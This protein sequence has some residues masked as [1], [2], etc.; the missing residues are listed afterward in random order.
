MSF[1]F[2]ECVAVVGPNGAGK[3]SLLRVLAGLQ[4]PQKGRVHWGDNALSDISLNDRPRYLSIMFSNYQR[5][6]GM[7]VNDIVAMG[8]QPYTGIFGKMATSDREA[9]ESALARV[10]MLDFASKPIENLS[11]G[12]FRKVMLAKMWAQDAQVMLFDE[13]TA[14]L[15]FPSALE[16]V[17]LLKSAAAGDGKAVVYSSHNLPLAFKFAD[18]VLVLCENGE[19][20]FDRPEEIVQSETF[21]SI[22]GSSDISIDPKDLSFKYN[23]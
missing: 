1:S 18:K 6:S 19:T 4:E 7:T 11:D 3:S 23:A 9:V 20:A 10:G 17:K 22:L 13:P 2:G 21:K 15:D 8:R 14:H 12:E 5:V 16:Y